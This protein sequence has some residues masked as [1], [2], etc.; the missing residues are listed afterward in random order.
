MLEMLVLQEQ[1]PVNTDLPNALTK[2]NQLGTV[3]RQSQTKFAE[4]TKGLVV[5]I[6]FE[7]NDDVFI[8]QIFQLLQQQQTHHEPDWLG[9]TA[10]TRA[11]IVGKC[12]FKLRPRN[13]RGKQA[14]TAD[15]VH[16]IAEANRCQIN[17][18]G[19]LPYFHLFD[20]K[21]WLY[22]NI[23]GRSDHRF[24][25][26]IFMLF[27]GLIGFSGQTNYNLLLFLIGDLSLCINPELV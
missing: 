8:T 9:R 23:F 21:T 11:V 15:R 22:F 5:G 26:I 17:W 1:K 7:L 24:F 19:A 10:N 6:A 4:A 12:F 20:R 27:N 3:T 16:P 13:N 25:E 18:F 14:V 2:M